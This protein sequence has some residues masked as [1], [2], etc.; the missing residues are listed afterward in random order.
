MK[1]K[2]LYAAAAL[3]ILAAGGFF[4]TNKICREIEELAKNTLAK[5]NIE[6]AE[7][8]YTFFSQT[9]SLKNIKFV[10]ARNSLKMDNSADE[11][12]IKGISKD[13]FLASAHDE[14]LVCD[15]IEFKNLASKFFAYNNEEMA[16]KTESLRIA[17]PM[18]NIKQL[19]ALHKTAPFSEEYFQCLLNVKHDGVQIDNIA[20]QAFKGSASQAVVKAKSVVLPPFS[21]K[22]FD[23]SYSG[24]A[25]SSSPLNMDIAEVQLQG[26]AIP[27]AAT[28]SGFSSTVVRLNELERSGALEDDPQ[29]FTEYEELSEKLL[30]YLADITKKPFS[31]I[32]VRG[33][34][35]YLNE[36][37]EFADKPLSMKEFTYRF[38]ENDKEINIVSDM[39]D[40]TVHKDFLTMLASP[41]SAKVVDGK[42]LDGLKLSLSTSSTFNKE[43]GEFSNNL[44]AA[45]PNLA[46]TQ[47]R[48]SGF[49]GNK[50]KNIFLY[51]FKNLNEYTSADELLAQLSQIFIKDAQLSY[52]DKGLI[53]ISYEI[54][55]AE[56]GLPKEN[57]KQAT[58][59]ELEAAKLFMSQ[60][61]TPADKDFVKIA[62]TLIQTI[63]KTGKFFA[64]LTFV[65][66]Y[67]LNE[68]LTADGFPEYTLE[69]KAE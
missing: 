25:L 13:N 59:A 65:K 51:S 43:N 4:L 61:N 52:E 9:L 16:T 40:F 37:P 46:D 5:N 3:L 44:R 2:I 11:I 39:Q 54:L 30:D 66:K 1:K 63:D 42:F 58:L 24:L 49:I 62:D 55:S 68:L 32:T 19:L 17:K 50:D 35:C 23:I 29:S 27:D 47:F 67:S 7:V 31:L 12:L 34:S 14:A 20:M 60:D 38:D 41:A 53:D 69:T 64:N 6:T 10:Y 56:T 15:E 21:G 45:V 26:F 8:K 22:T 18:L 33:L 57:I 36:I 48:F 28:L